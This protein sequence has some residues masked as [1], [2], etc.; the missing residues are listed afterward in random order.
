VGKKFFL[1][2]FL[3]FRGY[4]QCPLAYF[5]SFSVHGEGGWDKQ[6]GRPDQYRGEKCT[7]HMGSYLK[8][9]VTEGF[10]YFFIYMCHCVCLCALRPKVCK[11]F[12]RLSL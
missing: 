2:L 6:A 3:L 9:K 5:L 10:L 7:E 8:A 12:S 1:M 4:W 11:Q